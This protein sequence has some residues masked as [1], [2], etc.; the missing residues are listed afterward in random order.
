MAVG[1]KARWQSTPMPQGPA[2]GYYTLWVN[3]GSPVLGQNPKGISFTF[4][5]KKTRYPRAIRFIK[6]SFT[7][8]KSMLSDHFLNVESE[9]LFLSKIY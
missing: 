4:I 2:V 9:L 6:L 5:Y 8:S 1:S 3:G 7:T